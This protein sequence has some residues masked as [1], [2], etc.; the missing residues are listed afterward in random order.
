MHKKQSQESVISLAKKKAEPIEDV[1][2]VLSDVLKRAKSG[3]VRAVAI[4][5]STTGG[6]SG[7]SYCTGDQ[8]WGSIYLELDMLKAELRALAKATE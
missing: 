2:S 1:V 3:N 4:A 5:Y 6:A 7:W 8:P